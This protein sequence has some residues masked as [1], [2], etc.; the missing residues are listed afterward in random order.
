HDPSTVAAVI[1]EPVAGSTGCL[2]PPK[3][4]L[5]RLADIARANGI[6]LIFDEVI[7]AFGRLGHTFA[8][9]RYGVT[10]DMIAF[11]KGVTNGAVPMSGVVVSAPIHEAHMVGPE[12]LPELYHGYTYSGHPLA[13]AAALATLDV[14]RD[15]GL[16][17]R[18]AALEPLFAEAMMSLRGLPGVLDIRPV[19]VMC[20]IDLAAKDGTAGKRGLEITERG[21]HDY[22]MYVR[23][24]GDT[25]V[26]APPLIA[27]PDD[28]GEIRD[29]LAGLIQISS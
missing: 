2:P 16:A 25:I 21:Y 15:E 14:H 4:Y 11:A 29:K 22:G 3:G 17:G 1:V 23:V 18:A 20:G 28:V 5:T 12:H 10:P 9:E 8:A 6:L 27:T 24:A 26:V 19:G 7:T 13:V